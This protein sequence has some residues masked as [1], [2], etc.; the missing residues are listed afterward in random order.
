MVTADDATGDLLCQPGCSLH[1][2]AKRMTD[3]LLPAFVDRLLDLGRGSGEIPEIPVADVAGWLT[4][5]V[6]RLRSLMEQ[7]M[8]CAPSGAFLAHGYAHLPLPARDGRGI[9]LRLAHGAAMKPWPVAAASV[10][11]TVSGTVAL[12]MYRRPE[13]LRAGRPQY[14]RSFGPEQV[15]AAYPGTLCALQS[16]TDGMQVLAVTRPE[17]V[18]AG[19]LTFNEYAAVAQRARRALKVLVGAGVGGVR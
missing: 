16:S 15:F 7:G 3:G 5:L 11:L 8:P 2:K 18:S 9:Y 6:I 19:T 12:E 1:R 10:V 4:P 13:D 17:E 14:A